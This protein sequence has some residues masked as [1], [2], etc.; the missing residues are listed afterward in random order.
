MLTVMS[1]EVCLITKICE[2]QG[3]LEWPKILWWV[4][5]EQRIELG[6]LK[7][8]KKLTHW[9]KKSSI[10]WNCSYAVY[11]EAKK[12]KR[13]KRS[14]RIR[15]G[16]RERSREKTKIS[17]WKSHSHKKW[18]DSLEMRAVLLIFSLEREISGVIVQKI[19]QNSKKCRL[20]HSENDFE[21]VLANFFYDCAQIK[22]IITN[23]PRVL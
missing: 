3:G 14:G 18:K 7:G 15:E 22:K 5:R 17:H 12:R 8:H 2:G 20:L 19:H 10:Y 21:A 9:L 16:N 4:F 11:R 6:Q 23:A 1:K 13:T